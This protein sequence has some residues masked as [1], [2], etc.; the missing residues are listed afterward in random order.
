V[1]LGLA[2]FEPAERGRVLILF[3]AHSVPMM[4]VNKGEWRRGGG[5][6]RSGQR[7]DSAAAAAETEPARGILPHG[8][9][10][11]AH[12]SRAP[13]LA[14]PLLPVP[15]AGD[16][17]V[18]EVAATVDG[19]MKLLRRGARREASS[20]CSFCRSTR[21]RRP[22]LYDLARP[23]AASDAC[24]GVDIGDGRTDGG[25]VVNGVRGETITAAGNPH[26]LSWQS[27]VGFLPWM[28]PPTGATL[29]G[30]G[31]Q[32]S[33]TAVAAAAAVV[34]AGTR[35]IVTCSCGETLRRMVPLF[36]V[37][38]ALL[39]PAPAHRLPSQGHTHVLVVPV[40]FT[41]DHVETLFEIDLEY[42][43]AGVW[44]PWWTCTRA[45]R[46]L[47]AWQGR[48]HAARAA[49]AFITRSCDLR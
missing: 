39:L 8:Q 12:A 3:S 23:I 14:A 40:A 13:P 20:S 41:S 22:L 35:A 2:Q 11:C 36:T 10:Q 25:I 28:G 49:P 31:A 17:Y 42:R 5:G 18:N 32:V 43:C 4:V 16:P 21:P 19:V 7:G 37:P 9:G 45:R 46:S 47:W 26:L 27:K 15:A 1:A 34:V 33:E 38:H 29:K 48:T 6:G 44:W 30:L 24:A